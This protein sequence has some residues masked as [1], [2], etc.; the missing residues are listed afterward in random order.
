MYEKIKKKPTVY[1]EFVAKLI[2]KKILTKEYIEEKRNF[3]LK[4]YEEDYAKV[5]SDKNDRF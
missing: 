5:I 3:F 1:D 4:G 2:D